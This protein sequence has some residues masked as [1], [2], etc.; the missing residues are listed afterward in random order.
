MEVTGGDFR[1][2]RVWDWLC[3]GFGVDMGFLDGAA[4]KG[5]QVGRCDE[6][7]NEE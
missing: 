3:G 5:C 4:K 6:L 2:R 7:I 1:K